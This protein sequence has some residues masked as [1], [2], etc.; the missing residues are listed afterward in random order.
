MS[1]APSDRELVEALGGELEGAPIESLRRRPYTYATSAPLEEVRVTTAGDKE[2]AMILKDLDRARL[3][4]D[5]RTSKPPLLY[6]P[7]R[8]IETYGRIIGPEAIGPR[9]FAAVS[10]AGARRHWLLIEKVAGVELWQIGE[11]EVWEDA[12]RWVGEM[13]A[14]FRGRGP[15]LRELNPHLLEHTRAWYET[16][17]RRALEAVE[18]SGDERARALRA[19]LD[20]HG[21]VAAALAGLPQTLIHGEMYPANILVALEERPARIY[22]ID[23]EMTAIG[24]GVI[25]LA[26]MV[27]GWGE[28]ERQRLIAAYVQG[29]PSDVGAAELREAL[30]AA[31]LQ[32]ALQWLGW[33]EGWTPPPEHA[34]DWLAEALAAAAELRLA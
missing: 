7:R 14:R 25:D 31:R 20:D 26:A 21:R 30:A 33:G 13:H 29:A 11:L 16:W 17:G 34:N 9:L 2:I 18:A 27:A 22:P 5:A 15:E 8:E 6:E 19:V 4:G 12:A 3:L 28:A 10:D 23:W 32:L 1:E 24:P